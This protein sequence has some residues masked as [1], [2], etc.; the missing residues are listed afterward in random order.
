MMSV[1]PATQGKRAWQILASCTIPPGSATALPGLEDPSG[2]G[3]AERQRHQ[4]LNRDFA[5]DDRRRQILSLMAIV[6][7]DCP[8][9]VAKLKGETMVY[10]EELIRCS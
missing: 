4:Y 3:Y 5:A 1:L 6:G 8:L 10:G 2:P 9:I 7:H